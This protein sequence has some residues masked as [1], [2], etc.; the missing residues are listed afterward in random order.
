MSRNNYIL[1]R[2]GK[3]FFIFEPFYRTNYYFILA[4]SWKEARKFIEKFFKIDL[5]PRRDGDKNGYFIAL[6]QDGH[7]IGVIWARKNDHIN[8]AHEILH[9]VFW[10]MDNVGMELC[11]ESEEAFAYLHTFLMR[12]ILEGDIKRIKAK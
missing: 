1:K 11:A 3:I 10:T 7:D 4:D 9:A 12:A 6:N 2:C 5:K 8:L